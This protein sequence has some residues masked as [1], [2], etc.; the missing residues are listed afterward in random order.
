LFDQENFVFEF[1][2]NALASFFGNHRNEIEGFQ[3]LPPLLIGF[4]KFFEDM[5]GNFVA[6]ESPETFSG[7][8][9]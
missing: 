4:L 9:D 5:F 1:S 8:H 2:H 6:F 7:D 3:N